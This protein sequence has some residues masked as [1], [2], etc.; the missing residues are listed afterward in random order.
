MNTIEYGET[1]FGSF[2]IIDGENVHQHEYD[3]RSDEYIHQLKLKMVNELPNIIDRLSIFELKQIAEII[4][5]NNSQWEYDEEKS[6]HGSCDQ[7]G[8]YNNNDVYNRVNGEK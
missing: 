4:T 2:V 1:C 3:E 5:L 6:R 8:D 7:C